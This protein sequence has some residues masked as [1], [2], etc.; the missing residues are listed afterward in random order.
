MEGGVG[1]WQTGRGGVKKKGWD[2]RQLKGCRK[3]G[4]D[5]RQLKGCRKNGWDSRRQRGG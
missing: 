4:W 2:S 5:R 3:N 1:L